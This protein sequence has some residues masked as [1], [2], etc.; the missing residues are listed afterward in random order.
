M[1]SISSRMSLKPRSTSCFIFERA[2]G[3]SRG[4]PTRHRASFRLGRSY[5]DLHN[6]RLLTGTLGR[7][8]QGAGIGDVE[9]EP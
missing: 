2:T 1:T 9:S 5:V 3:G 8:V 6:A 7:M 4:M